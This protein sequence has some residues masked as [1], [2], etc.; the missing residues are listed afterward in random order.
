ML[1]QTALKSA[2]ASV[3]FIAASQP[4]KSFL[5]EEWGAKTAVLLTR[6][7]PGFALTTGRAVI[8]F[9]VAFA[10]RIGE[11]ATFGKGVFVP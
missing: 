9:T 8:Q 10:G 7:R 1:I 6:F 11:R 3:V 2:L 5:S 4:N